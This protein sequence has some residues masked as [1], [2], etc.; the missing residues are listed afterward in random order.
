M[1]QAHEL[2]TAPLEKRRTVFL[3]VFFFMKAL[4]G[5]CADCV[6]ARK[7][8]QTSDNQAEMS[9]EADR[10]DCEFRQRLRSR[11]LSCVRAHQLF[12]KGECETWT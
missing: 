9:K 5:G 10:P 6:L 8:A 1:R 3:G 2:M 7:A 4:S 11:R 12:W